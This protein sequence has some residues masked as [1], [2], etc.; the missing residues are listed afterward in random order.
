VYFAAVSVEESAA[1][2]KDLGGNVLV[3]TMPVPAGAFTVVADPQGAV[4][5]LSEGEF[6]D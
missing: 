4:F 2:V 3:P 5:G 6:D 1:K